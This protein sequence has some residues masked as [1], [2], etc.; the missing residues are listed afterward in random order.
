[1][2]TVTRVIRTGQQVSVQVHDPLSPSGTDTYEVDSRTGE[3]IGY[4]YMRGTLVITTG[5]LQR[6]DD[7]GRESILDD[8]EPTQRET[9][10][11]IEYEGKYVPL[12]EVYVEEPGNCG[13]RHYHASRNGTAKTLDGTVVSDAAPQ[14]CGYGKVDEKPVFDCSRDGKNCAPAPAPKKK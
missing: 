8:L 6:W 14:H 4:P 5:F 2:V 3:L 1:M 9:V 12:S 13:A 7:S 10:K 11:A